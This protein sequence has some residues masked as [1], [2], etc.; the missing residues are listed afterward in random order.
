MNKME[1]INAWEKKLSAY[2]YA[3]T[4]MGLDNNQNPPSEG[5]EYRNERR[6]ILMREFYE[7]LNDPKIYELLKELKD[8]PELNELEKR[9]VSLHL[10]RLEE[11][12]DVPMEVRMKFQN[13]LSESQYMWLKYKKEGNYEAYAP[14]LK[15]VFESYEE[16][17]RYELT[18][19]E[20]LFDHLLTSHIAGFDSAKYD[21][22]F[23]EVKKELIP[24]IQTIKKQKQID[25][26]FLKKYYP[27]EKQRR[28]NEE[29]RNYVHFNPSWGKI[30]ESEHPLT[31]TVARGD[32]RFT[33][34]YR[35]NDLV[36]ATFS[37]IHESGHAYFN[38]QVSAED[39]G[40]I[41]AQSISAALHES[42]SRLCE[43]HLGRSYPFWEV[44]YPKLQKIFPEE[45]SR[46]SLDTFYHA[47]SKVEPSLVRTEADEVTYPLHIIIRYEI[48]KAVFRHEVAF[49]DIRDLWNRKY[50]EYLG[51]KAENDRDGIL[52]DMHWPYAYFGYFPTY[53][54]GSAFAAQFDAAMRKEIDVD[55]YLRNS[56]YPKVMAWLKEHV[57]CYGNRIDPLEVIEAATAEPF[58][59]QYYFRYLKEKYAK[60][61]E[62]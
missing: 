36:Q 21:A 54:L 9:K 62:L 7:V 50:E 59:P 37:T 40:T 49:E 8:D 38:H 33:T 45:L 16:M 5:R 56:E 58:D 22:F 13:A 18:D 11:G 42:Q 12:K 23:E 60:I 24:F 61:Y 25:D 28:F 17:M 29:I 51:V 2:Q 4:L 57:H 47:I 6:A 1:T 55:A 32:I 52:Q 46:I 27:A 19:G 43:N 44:N 53:L 15:A 48:E 31:T 20:D 41:L 30:A 34:K 10:K 14:Y 35:E 39:E 3:F 26:S